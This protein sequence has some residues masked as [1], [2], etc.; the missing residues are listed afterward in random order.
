MIELSHA[1]LRIQPVGS[2]GAFT[3][4]ITQSQHFSYQFICSSHMTMLD[5]FVEVYLRFL[6]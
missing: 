6:I 5:E 1:S 3:L 4:S 2:R